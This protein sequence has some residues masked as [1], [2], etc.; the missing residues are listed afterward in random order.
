MKLSARNLLKGKILSVAKDQTTTH[1]RIDIG[2]GAVVTSSITDE[3]LHDL[4]LKDGDDTTSV[5]K[6]S[7]VM[8][9]K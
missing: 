4:A 2:G 1:A 7:A 3:A 5:I 9:A 6:A 8:I